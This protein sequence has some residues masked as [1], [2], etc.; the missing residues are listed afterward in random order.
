MCCE[1]FVTKA[2][3][4][5]INKQKSDSAIS[6]GFY[7]HKTSHMRSFPKIKSS[8]KFPYLQ[9]LSWDKF[10]ESLYNSVFYFLIHYY[11]LTCCKENSVDP[12]QLNKPAELD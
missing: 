8:R 4:T 10:N 12:D 11:E 7:F 5:Y 9:Y 3:F 1:K 2:R 6:Q